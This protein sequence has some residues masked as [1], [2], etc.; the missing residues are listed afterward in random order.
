MNKIYIKIEGMVC[1]HCYETVTQIIKKDFNVK[2]V[3]VKRNIATI[4]YE[5]DINTERIKKEIPVKMVINVDKKYL[6]G[7]NN[8]IIMKKFGIDQKFQ[9]GKN[10]INFLPTEEGEFLYSC[11]MNMIYNKIKVIN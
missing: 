9:V 6:T 7:C 1:N 10:E 3:K 4:W 11:W 5:N 2:K 8:G